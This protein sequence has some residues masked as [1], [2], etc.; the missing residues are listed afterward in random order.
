MSWYKIVA[1]LSHKTFRFLKNLTNFLDALFSGFWLGVMGKKSIDFSDELYYNKAKSYSNDKYNESGFFGWEK[2]I[3]EKYFSGAK[4]ILL[5]A[6]GGG[7][8]VI[9]LNKMGIEVD[10]YECNPKLVEFGN[11]LLEKHDINSRIKSL[12]RN[13][14]PEDIKQ[15]DGIIIGWGAYSLI[16]GRETRIGFLNSI[17]PFFKSDT[18]LMVSF[19][20]STRRSRKDKIIKQV[21]DFLT[22]L[23]KKSR[24]EIGDRLVPNFI[25]YFSEEE[26]KSEFAQADLEVIDY[27]SSDYGCLIARS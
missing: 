12:A 9:A 17:R 16:R 23:H 26:I 22:F 24:A 21:S 4:S 11:L 18:C 27:S 14:V 20:Y 3:I 7:R 8:E 15:Y 5:I 25:H 19:I 13:S 2:P 6:A 1:R 10:A